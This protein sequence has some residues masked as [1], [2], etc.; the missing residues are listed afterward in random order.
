MNF[1]NN[2]PFDKLIVDV[3]STRHHWYPKWILFP[4]EN[5]PTLLRRTA[6][7]QVIVDYS[8]DASIAL[9]I[10]KK[11]ESICDAMGK[12]SWMYPDY[13]RH[14]YWLLS[15]ST[16]DDRG[17][18]PFLAF[19]ARESAEQ[20]VRMRGGSPENQWNRGRI[21]F[22]VDIWRIWYKNERKY[23]EC[24]CGNFGFEFLEAIETTELFV[25]RVMAIQPLFMMAIQPL[26]SSY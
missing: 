11:Q 17:W 5:H 7:R 1:A 8:I 24:D 4:S 2:L 12:I 15:M 9:P 25:G 19:V 13:R 23:L 10:P 16:Y 26:A 18:I 14:F 3:P 6:D 20:I 22:A 21:E